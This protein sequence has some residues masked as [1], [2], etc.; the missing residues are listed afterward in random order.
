MKVNTSGD[1]KKA[2]YVVEEKGAI[3]GPKWEED[4]DIKAFSNPMSADVMEESNA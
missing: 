3:N 1:D 2:A 4:E